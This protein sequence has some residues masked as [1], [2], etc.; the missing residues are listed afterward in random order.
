[1]W[2]WAQI[3]L[4]VYVCLQYIVVSRKDELHALLICVD[5]CWIY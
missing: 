5:R 4:Y 3:L 2:K 1:M